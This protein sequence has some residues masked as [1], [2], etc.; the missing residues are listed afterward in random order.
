MTKTFHVYPSDAGWVVRKEGRHAETYPTQRAAVDAA[1]QSIKDSTQGQLVIHKRDG[2]IRDH[3]TYG[4]PRVQDP[5]KK[6]RLA[7]QI[8]RAVE[9]V[10]LEG[11][12]PD[13]KSASGD[14]SQK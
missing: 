11:I 14:S 10:T 1:R 9:K 6:S 5:P 4:M 8:E 2:S 7:K 12:H 3:Q 13:S